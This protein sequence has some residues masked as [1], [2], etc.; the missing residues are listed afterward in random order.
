VLIIGKAGTANVRVEKK[1]NP[2][3]NAKNSTEEKRRDVMAQTFDV[4]NVD[5]NFVSFIRETAV[6]LSRVPREMESSRKWNMR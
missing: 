3:A 2:K 4:R 5:Q 6:P 1:H